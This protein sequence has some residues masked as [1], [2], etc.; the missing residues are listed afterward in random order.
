MLL[1]ELDLIKERRDQAFIRS[2]NYQQAAAKSYKTHVRCR[3]F[4][5]AD[6]VLR[7]CFQNTAEW[8]AGKLGTNWE[9]PYKI[10]KVVRVGA[11]EIV[12]MQDIKIPRI[13]NAMH[14]NKY[15]R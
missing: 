15:Y 10:I 1:D 13:W 14:L 12:N 8:N 7:K 5:E 3:R 11:Y 6:L 4:K 9:G 2:Q